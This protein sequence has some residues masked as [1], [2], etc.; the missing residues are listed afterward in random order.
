MVVMPSDKSPRTTRTSL[1]RAALYG[2]LS[3][4]GV[5]ALHSAVSSTPFIQI[6]PAPIESL[7]EFV[8]YLLPGVLVFSLLAWVS[9]RRVAASGPPPVS[10]GASGGASDL[11]TAARLGNVLYWIGCGV[12]ALW[13]LFLLAML[14]ISGVPVRGDQTLPTLLYVGVTGSI[15]WLIGRACRYVLAGR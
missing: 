1:R 11:S 14:L 13:V 8:G 2:A 3:M 10:H 4:M 5:R 7:F 15:P 12:A 9:N 6:G